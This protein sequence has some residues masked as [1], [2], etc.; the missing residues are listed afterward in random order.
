MKQKTYYYIYG[1][2]ENG[3]LKGLT[4]DI[5][6]YTN[7]RETNYVVPLLDE[8]GA[9]KGTL[10]QSRYVV[11]VGSEWATDHAKC[12]IKVDDG[13]MASQGL[14]MIKWGE[15]DVRST[16]FKHEQKNEYYGSATG[17][18]AKAKRVIIHS[19]DADA[20]SM[21]PY[22]TPIKELARGYFHGKMRK[23]MFDIN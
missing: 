7:S 14:N 2:T 4:Y 21:E 5:Q 22:P 18:L 23:I 20:H 9:E 17:I 11:G 1:Q 19:V 13:S 10:C 16:S 12:F 15:S 8:Y 3:E 6:D